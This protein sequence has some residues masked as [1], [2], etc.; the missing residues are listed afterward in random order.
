M[1]MTSA[2]TEVWHRRLACDPLDM[3][4]ETPALPRVEVP[5][6]ALKQLPCGHS[7]LADA[8][9][10]HLRLTGHSRLTSGLLESNNHA[11]RSSQ[12]PSRLCSHQRGVMRR[13]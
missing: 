7:Y 10:G 13:R 5:Q 11:G 8:D 12:C 6:R 4:G 3:T 9:T 2:A 1:V